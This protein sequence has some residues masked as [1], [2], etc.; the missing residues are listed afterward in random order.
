[1]AG[2]DSPPWRAPEWDVSESERFFPFTKTVRPEYRGAYS[3]RCV[4]T[5]VG[6]SIQFD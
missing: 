1:M 3:Q 5:I 4:R 2:L 6:R